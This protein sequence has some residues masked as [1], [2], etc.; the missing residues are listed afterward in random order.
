MFF[1]NVSEL[2]NER[3]KSNNENVANELFYNSPSFSD[4]E[5]IANIKAVERLLNELKIDYD[6]FLTECSRSFVYSKTVA[7]A[8]A[9]NATRQGKKDEIAIIEG[10]ANAMRDYGYTIQLCG[11]NELRPCKD[12][13]MRNEYQFK[14]D[15]LNKKIDSLKSVDAIFNGPRNGYIFA[16]NVIGDGGHQDNVVKEID[17]YM[18]WAQNYG[19]NDKIYVMLIDGKSFD[20]LRSRETH[21]IWVV[22]TVEFQERLIE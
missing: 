8:I 12:G 14:K 5:K 15:N 4:L 9:K 3:Q 1:T 16:K 22:N 19:E 21:N 7:F 10:I 17:Q 6:E 13:Q 18:E 2:R 11:T 20:V